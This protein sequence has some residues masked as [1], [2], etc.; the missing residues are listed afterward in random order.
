MKRIFFFLCILSFFLAC[1]T[2]VVRETTAPRK[3]PVWLVKRP[4]VSGYY[5]GVGGAA[6]NATS[7]NHIELAKNNALNDLVTEISVTISA[8]SVIRQFENNEEFKEEFESYSNAIIRDHIQDYELVDSWGDGSYYWV[9]YR[10]SRATYKAIKQ[11]KLENAKALAYDFYQK[12]TQ[13]QANNEI[14][15]ALSF[16]MKAFGSLKNYLDED[17]SHDAANGE[18]IL[19]GNEIIKGISQLYSRITLQLE[20]NKLSTTVAK[21]LDTAFSLTALY[22]NTNGNMVPLAGLPIHYAFTKGEGVV[23]ERSVTDAQGVTRFSVM[24]VAGNS[25]YQEITAS[26]DAS[27]M[28][29]GEDATSEMAKMMLEMIDNKPLIQLRIDAKPILAYFEANETEFDRSSNRNAM[30]NEVKKYFADR[31]FSFTTS[32]SAADVIVQLN[33]R[34]VKGSYNERHRLH[35]VFIDCYVA[36]YDAR[37][38]NKIYYKG[39][40]QVRGQQVGTWENGLKDAQLNTLKRIRE[41]ILPEVHRLDF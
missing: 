28:I 4:V 21:P 6:V 3:Q 24:R 30:T 33:S 2:R 41:E 17:L 7:G 5:T 18:T 32:R 37:T 35:T 36:I 19:L 22:R 23:Q 27:A 26:V 10:L 9:Y 1:K 25:L 15:A 13:M 20:V 29:E 40:D 31:S 16:Y 14:S 38:E 11:R 8:N 12:A 39:F 34:A